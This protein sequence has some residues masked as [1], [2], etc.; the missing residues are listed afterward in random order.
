[1]WMRSCAVCN[2]VLIKDNLY[3]SVRCQCGWEWEDGAEEDGREEVVEVNISEVAVRR[4][5]K[6]T[7]LTPA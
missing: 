3:G 5:R 4:Q 1:M 2:A 7:E 6:G